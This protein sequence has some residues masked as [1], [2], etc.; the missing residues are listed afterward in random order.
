MEK[1]LLSRQ[2]QADVDWWQRIASWRQPE[3]YGSGEDSEPQF[4]GW[5]FDFV[6]F[7]SGKGEFGDIHQ[8]ANIAL[9]NTPFELID[10][11]YTQKTYEM[12]L[13]A[14]FVGVHQAEDGAVRPATGWMLYMDK[15]SICVPAT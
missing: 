2:G 15:N 14:G 6:H 12:V 8:T 13:K 10:D 3:G 4:D 9:T 7:H 1:I 11:V 5:I